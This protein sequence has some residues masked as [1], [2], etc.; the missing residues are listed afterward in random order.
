MKLTP[1]QR[2]DLMRRV[3]LMAEAHNRTCSDDLVAFWVEE[4]APHYGEHL[5]E[6]IRL[7]M[8]DKWMPSVNELLER[9][10]KVSLPARTAIAEQRYQRELEAY[11]R[12][13]LLIDRTVGVVGDEPSEPH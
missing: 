6:A 11:R 8:R 4:L 7:C 3:V 5:F 1:E 10:R 13:P 2:R 12:E 9:E